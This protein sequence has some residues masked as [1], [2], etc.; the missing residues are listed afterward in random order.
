MLDGKQEALYST[1]KIVAKKLKA[2]ICRQTNKQC[3]VQNSA[4]QSW[5]YIQYSFKRLQFLT[6][7]N[8]VLNFDLFVWEINKLYYSFVWYPTSAAPKSHLIITKMP[9]SFQSITNTN[10]QT[11]HTKQTYTCIAMYVYNFSSLSY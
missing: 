1:T 3:L 5:A 4:S 2:L 9:Y 6:H 11:Q 7:H 10:W 8:P